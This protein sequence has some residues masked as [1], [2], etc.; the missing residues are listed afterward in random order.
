MG[1]RRSGFPRKR[2]G[3]AA[4]RNRLSGHVPGEHVHPDRHVPGSLKGIHPEYVGLD[5]GGLKEKRCGLYPASLR[6]LQGM[7][8]YVTET[9]EG[10]VPGLCVPDYCEVIGKPGGTDPGS[11]LRL[12]QRMYVQ[13]HGCR[14]HGPWKGILIPSK[15]IRLPVPCHQ[16][17]QACTETLRRTYPETVG[18][19]K[20]Y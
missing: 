10:M 11:R 19:G 6:E 7:R 16:P 1:S 3:T 12:K 20:R 9:R 8:P 15:R 2:T 5:P 13:C 18:T 4:G 14:G 17:Y